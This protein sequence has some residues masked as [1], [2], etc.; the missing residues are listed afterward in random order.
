MIQFA[1]KLGIIDDPKNKN[2]PK[3]IHTYPVPRGGGLAIFAAV[4]LTSILFLPLDKHLLGILVGAFVLTALGV[5]DDK[6]DLSPY[7]RLAIQ[8]LAAGI[9]IIAGIGI[10]FATIPFLGKIDL[11][12]A[13]DCFRIIGR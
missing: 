6:K 5:I 10:A 4:F 2:H 8:F 7:K 13:T 1:E 12:P 11:S 3:V 9:P